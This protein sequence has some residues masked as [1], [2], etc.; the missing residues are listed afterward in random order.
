MVFVVLCWALI[1]FGAATALA[2]TSPVM[3]LSAQEQ[4]DLKKEAGAAVQKA[5]RTL[6]L[7]LYLPVDDAGQRQM[8]AS[9]K[10]PP[11]PII[12]PQ[13]IATILLVVALLVILL[14]I[15]LTFKDN[16][17][18]NSRAKKLERSVSEEEFSPAAT[19]ARMGKAQLAADELAQQGNY[20]EA[21]HVLLLQSVNELRMRLEVSIAVSLT[22]REILQYIGLPE[23]G[24]EVFADIVGRV[25][26][27]YYG[28]HQPDESEYLACRESYDTLTHILKQHGGAA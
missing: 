23:E 26:I 28:T 18:S 19:T 2:Q 7:Q 15:L 27:S 6:D 13:E 3:P 11:K 8:A 21:M 5:Q 4:A 14:V 9:A 22:S 10:P 16:M 17:W 1:L 12:I 20:A 24:Y 25:E